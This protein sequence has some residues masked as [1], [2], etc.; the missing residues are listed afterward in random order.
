MRCIG[1]DYG[2]RRLGLAYGDEVGVA[3]PLPAIASGDPSRRW[4]VLGTLLRERRATDVVLGHPLNMDG[5]AGPKAIEV[6]EFAQR[7]NSEFGIPVHLI[8]ERLTTYE[9]EST[10][11]PAKRRSV[12]T[13][14]LVDSRAATIILQDYLDGLTPGGAAQARE[15]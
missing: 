14:G 2:E 8:D 6:E 5:S 7:I 4:A 3:T 15:P 1:I 9:A 11:A 10:I 13:T 12:R